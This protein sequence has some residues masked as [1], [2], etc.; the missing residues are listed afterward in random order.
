MTMVHRIPEYASLFGEA[1]DPLDR[2]K[3]I[4][5]EAWAFDQLKVHIEEHVRKHDDVL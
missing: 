2:A 3:A 5:G 4:F 1:L